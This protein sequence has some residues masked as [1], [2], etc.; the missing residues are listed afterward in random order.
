MYH[1]ELIFPESSKNYRPEYK[2]YWRVI[3]GRRDLTGPLFEIAGFMEEKS[4]DAYI[5]HLKKENKN[6]DDDKLYITKLMYALP[7]WDISDA[8]LLDNKIN[9]LK[10]FGSHKQ[11]HDETNCGNDFCEF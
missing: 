8:I 5:E 3:I 7:P 4:A 11:T 6:W 9:W 2:Y 1:D 10:E